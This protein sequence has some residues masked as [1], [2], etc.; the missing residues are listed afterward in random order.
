MEATAQMQNAVDLFGDELPDME[1]LKKLSQQVHATESGIAAFAEQVEQNIAKTGAKGCL[2]TG[3]GLFILGKDADAIGKL[4]K[5]TDC[6]EKFIYLA[7]TNRRLGSFD[8][9]IKNLNAAAKAGADALEISLE[10]TA[11]HREARN[12]EA[13]EKELK[14]CA[15]FKNVSAE[16]HYQLGRLQEAQG[17]YYEAMENYKAAL[18]LSPGHHRAAFHLAYRCDIEGQEDAAID[19]YKQIASASTVYVN[20]LLNLA[21]IYEDRADYDKAIKCVEKVLAC[22]PNHKRAI[23][24]L[25]DITS[26][27]TMVHD[28]ETEKRVTRK[29]QILET[30]I[31]DFELS[32]RSRNC[33]K[34]MNINTL[35][36]LLRTTEADLLAFKNFGETSL[37]EIK[38]IL[39]IKGLTLGTG[40]EE[41][42][43]ISTEFVE[44]ETETVEKPEQDD[45]LSGKLIND[46]Q[47]SVRVKKALAGLNIRTLGDLTATTEAELLGCKN[48]GVTSLNEIKKSLENLGLSLRTL[49]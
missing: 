17:Q 13:A 33:L 20:A 12:Y 19:Y 45:G 9:A 10:K 8:E 4:E 18:E 28:E 27:K 21:V 37:K 46:L 49:D 23:L 14:G 3:I 24:F 1:Q 38:A 36:D 6:Q 22:H 15:N 44:E 11:T 48:F 47:W 39:N 7:Y 25:K 42:Q 29:L 40:T 2:A 41:K 26:S 32:V 34:K 43:L 16:Y 30:P 35:G 31:S 5:G